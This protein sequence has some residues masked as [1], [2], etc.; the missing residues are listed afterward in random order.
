[1][2]YIEIRDYDLIKIQNTVIY[3]TYFAALNLHENNQNQ[4]FTSKNAST[5]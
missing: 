2:V 5:F 1:M 3:T 4:T